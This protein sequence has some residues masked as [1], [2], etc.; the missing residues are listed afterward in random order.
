MKTKTIKTIIGKKINQWLETIDD[1]V[2]RQACKED[3]IVTG[4]SIASMLL[5]QDV[6]DF[7]VYFKT[8]FTVEKIT[9]H[10]VSK[11]NKIYI[12]S[13]SDS[14]IGTI[15]SNSI[16]KKDYEN[17]V[18]ISQWKQFKKGLER[19]KEERIKVYIPHVGYW[20]KSD[21]KSSKDIEAP[22]EN[23]FEPIYLTENAITLS[24][25]VQLVI[26]F[27]GDADKIHE[28]YDFA[29]ATSYF[30][31]DKKS[32]KYELVLRNK[33][34]EALL[35]KEL[36]YI[37]SKYPLTSVIRTKKFI[38]RGFTIS[39]GT[40]LKILWQVAELDLKDPIVLQEQLLGV[41]IAWFSLLIE[42]ISKVNPKDLTYNFIS[43]IIDRVFNDFDE[44]AHEYQPK[45]KPEDTDLP[46]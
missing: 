29:H 14:T 12:N 31:Y 39:A 5:Q 25:D 35:T 34:M 6:N 18:E 9:K 28:N 1:P 26:R 21:H 42:I 41:D 32:H 20:R 22:K 4:G 38:K 36:I 40:Y 30:H 33:A 8:K 16:P 27:F 2:L 19:S 3:F 17:E 43:E 46:I 23:T 7:D 44:D 45:E 11:I 24:D 13:I 10:Y 15:D 37:G